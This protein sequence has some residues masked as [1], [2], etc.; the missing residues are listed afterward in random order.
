[1]PGEPRRRIRTA[2]IALSAAV[3]AA[4]LTIAPPPSGTPTASAATCAGAVPGPPGNDLARQIF[5]G[6]SGPRGAITVL[7]D[8]V[9]QGA[10]FGVTLP[11]MLAD[12]GWGPIRFRSGLGYNTGLGGTSTWEPSVSNW[13]CWWRSQGWNP[14]PIAV[15]LG[16]NDVGY[17]NSLAACKERIAFLLDEIGPDHDVW[18]AMTTVFSATDQSNWNTALTEL[19]AERPNLVLWD[20]P[21]ALAASDILMS[22]DNTHLASTRDYEKR[23]ALMAADISERIGTPARHVGGDAAVPTAAADPAEFLPLA[24]P[25]RALDTRQP[26]GGG[27]LAAD[28]MREVDLSASVPEGATAVA[29]NVT[30]ANAAEAGF[31]TVW[32]CTPGR[33]DVSNVNFTASGARGAHAVVPVSAERHVCVYSPVA[34]DVLID[35]QGSFVAD[36]GMTLTPALARLADTRLT[37]RLEVVVAQVPGAVAAVV[38]L[39]AID[40]SEQGYLTAY[41]C[42]GSRPEVSSVNFG[43]HEVIAGSAY[44]PVSADGTICVYA[45]TPVDVLIDLTGTFAA[46]DGG[47]RFVAANPARMLDTRNAI[48]G[49]RGRQAPGQ[50]IDIAVAPAGARAVTGTLTVATAGLSTYLTAW[51]CG[52]PMPD[53]SNLNAPVA[54]TVANSLTVGVSAE[55]RLC[56]SSFSSGD[57]LFD[58]TG[59]W[60]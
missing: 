46:G 9:L 44:V 50:E 12:H 32:P 37:G 31:L 5:L 59:W 4:A 16:A 43:P 22:F 54:G 15:N 27:P 10:A 58:T 11:Q 48:G 51:A 19:A 17:C 52:D 35:V 6:G 24:V 13:I 28:T 21:A 49:W 53:T 14:R 7:G 41:A 56:V 25:V 8:S 29:I 1:M 2:T 23:S 39:T 36:D 47:L 34:T 20:W 40:A 18:W 55:S 26:G 33:P 3:A 45:S 57:T 30:A 42:D 60:V 38:N